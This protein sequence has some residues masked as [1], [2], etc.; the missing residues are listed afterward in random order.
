MKG[1]LFITPIKGFEGLYSITKDGKV[2]SHRTNRYVKT[3]KSNY[4]YVRLYKDSKTYHYSIH[5]LLAITFIPNP[6]NKG[7]VDHIDNN[8]FNNNLNNLQWLSQK[9]NI[10]K[11]YDTMSQLRNFTECNLYYKDEFIKSFQS[12]S[13]CCRFCNTKYGLSYSGMKKYKKKKDFV[14]KCVEGN[15]GDSVG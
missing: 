15:C 14:I 11:S 13:E 8:P 7:V 2:Y 9:E 10:H 6:Y 3:Y 12:I 1:V 4:E 5:R